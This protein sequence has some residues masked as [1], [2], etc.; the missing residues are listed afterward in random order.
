MAN[1]DRPNGA[2][3]VGNITGAPVNGKMRKY[4]VDVSNAVAI[5]PGDFISLEADG[6]VKASTTSDRI[7]GVCMGVNV[8]MDV[9]AT[10][11]PGY[12]PA[13]TVG[14]ILVNVDPNSLYEVQEDS[15][16]SNLALD[17]IGNLADVAVGSGNTATGTSAHEIDSSDIGTG[18][19][20]KIVDLVDKADNALGANAKWIVKINEAHFVGETGI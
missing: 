4:N 7:L 14:T 15:V 19:Q 8:D 2:V 11:H 10:E 13:T 12:L 18:A 16:G 6:N 5:F 9:S 17:S 20:L 3:L 1:I